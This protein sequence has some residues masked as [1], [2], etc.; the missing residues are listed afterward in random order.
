MNQFIT[1]IKQSSAIQTLLPSPQ[2][3]DKKNPPQQNPFT[4][5]DVFSYLAGISKM[6]FKKFLI[7]TT[8]G[9]IPLIYI[10][11][12]LGEEIITKN[13]LLFNIFLIIS[14]IYVLIFIYL[15][16]RKGLFGWI[17]KKFR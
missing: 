11:S 6:N 12:Y 16:I 14:L 3:Q 9:L 1:G 13:E 2:I 5:S 10:Q 8:L 7:G 4:S 17:M 15:I